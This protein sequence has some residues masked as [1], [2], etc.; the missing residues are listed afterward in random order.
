MWAGSCEHPGVVHRVY[1]VGGPGRVGK[2]S[3]AQRLLLS[4]GIPWLPTDVLRTVLRRVL[5]ELDE[6]DQGDVPAAAVSELMYPHLE[7]AVEVCGEEAEQFLIEGP[8]IV[9]AMVARLSAA[10]PGITVRA[11][12]LGNSRFS[13]N[14]LASQGYP[15]KRRSAASRVLEAAQAAPFVGVYSGY[16]DTPGASY[17]GPKPQHEDASRAELEVAAAWIRAESEHYRSECARLVL[18]YV[19]VGDLGLLSAAVAA[20][21][22]GLTRSRARVG[23]C[24]GSSR[25]PACALGPAGRGPGSAAGNAGAGRAG[26]RAGRTSYTGRRTCADYDGSRRRCGRGQPQAW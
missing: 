11:C 4:D 5:P 2:S 12:F 3:L 15:F 24:C 9:P 26:R 23:C 7:Q 21:P 25:S 22:P 17:R 10:V 16:M 14:D 18:P 19:D 20:E 8:D 13:G 1:L 6:L